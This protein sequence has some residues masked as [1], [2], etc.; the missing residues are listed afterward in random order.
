MGGVTPPPA[1][2]VKPPRADGIRTVF[3]RSSGLTERPLLRESALLRLSA[4]EV[5]RNEAYPSKDIARLACG[6]VALERADDGWRAIWRREGF[7][8]EY[9]NGDWSRTPALEAP[10]IGYAPSEYQRK[11]WPKEAQIE[12]W[13]PHCFAREQQSFEVVEDANPIVSNKEQLHPAVASGSYAN[14][15]RLGRRALRRTSRLGADAE[16]HEMRIRRQ[17]MG[18]VCLDLPFH[19]NHH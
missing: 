16:G 15:G 3:R 18:G 4:R 2:S 10:R 12:G 9:P 17:R 11:P 8:G 6:R 19:R 1:N 7:E 5:R 13:F 14:C